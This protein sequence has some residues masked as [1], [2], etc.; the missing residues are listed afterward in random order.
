[1]ENRIKQSIENKLV[2]KIQK[3]T[4]K[5]ESLEYENKSLKTEMTEIKN[6]MSQETAETL[7]QLNKT[8]DLAKEANKKANFNEQ[9]SRKNN[10]KVL[11]LK[12]N[13]TE[14]E[15]SLK[16]EVCGLFRE[17]QLVV[18]S[19]DILAIH[20][21]PGKRGSPRPAI[22]KLKNN[23]MKS[24]I[25]KTRKFMREKGHRIVDDVTRLNTGLIS[26]LLLHD[27]IKSAWFFNGYVFGLTKQE[28]RIKFDIYDTIDT[29]ISEFRS[30]K[31]LKA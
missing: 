27:N 15:E 29:T 30:R 12:E 20:R 1:M 7:E 26:R 2:Q 13:S 23:N 18:E 6:K 31:V 5:I 16:N 21:I 17:H 25:M 22:I 3:L 19:D 11:D 28:E 8:Y 14:T 4:D 9:Y 24:S 10:V